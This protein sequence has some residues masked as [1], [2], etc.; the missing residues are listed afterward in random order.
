[1]NDLPK[2]V[3]KFTPGPW[4][5]ERCDVTPCYHIEAGAYPFG[6]SVC[7]I[8]EAP[9]EGNAE[10]NARLIAAAPDLFA[11]LHQIS[12]IEG[13]MDKTA[14]RRVANLAREAIR[15]ATQI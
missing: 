9:R 2:E 12:E 4:G 13:E 7:E 6:T 3:V 8:K 1:M 10:A 14:T 11:A 5:V 15:K